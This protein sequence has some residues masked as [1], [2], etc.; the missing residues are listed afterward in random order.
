[1]RKAALTLMGARAI[2]G[3]SGRVLGFPWPLD[4]VRRNVRGP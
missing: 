4:K 2:S 1:M 3:W